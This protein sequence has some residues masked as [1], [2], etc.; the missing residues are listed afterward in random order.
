MTVRALVAL[1]LVSCG[2]M[3]GRGWALAD[4]PATW[5]LLHAIASQC[6]RDDTPLAD[7][8]WWTLQKVADDWYWFGRDRR[9]VVGQWEVRL[10]LDRAAVGDG[11]VL[12]GEA[13]AVGGEMESGR[14]TRD[15]R[16]ELFVVARP[17]T[18]LA[19]LRT[20]LGIHRD[21]R[22]RLDE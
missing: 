1:V 10:V 5:E 18:T 9:V 3:A 2:T 14:V 16:Q 4:L 11:D 6:G 22:I 19:R 12:L 8:A 21:P 20:F 7:Q 15:I 17:T 13:L